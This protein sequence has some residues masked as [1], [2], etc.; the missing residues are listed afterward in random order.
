MATVYLLEK[1]LY[2]RMDL[3]NV[4]AISALTI[5]AVRRSEIT[6]A[7]FLLSFA[8]VTT[9]GTIAVPCIARSREPYR[10]ALDH[11]SAVTR[12]VSHSPRRN[13]IPN[14]NARRNGMDF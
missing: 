9:F 13:S 3:L 2:R 12:D 1:L 8:A 4:A 11:M 14:R 7:S 10:L 5:L 6:D